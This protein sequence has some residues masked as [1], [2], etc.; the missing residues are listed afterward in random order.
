MGAKVVRVEHHSS[1]PILTDLSSRLIPVVGFSL[2][3]SGL[4]R[5]TVG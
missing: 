5:V 2:Q 1:C 4:D 3:L